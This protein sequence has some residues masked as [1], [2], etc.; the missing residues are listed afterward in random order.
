LLACRRVHD[1]RVDALRRPGTAEKS[2][3]DPDEGVFMSLG[4]L[5]FVK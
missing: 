3:I 1:E 4:W 5:T 2:R